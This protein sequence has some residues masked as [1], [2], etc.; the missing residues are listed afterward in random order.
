MAASFTYSEAS[1]VEVYFN[2][3][4]HT[5]VWFSLFT[6]ALRNERDTIKTI[7]PTLCLFPS[8]YLYVV[9]LIASDYSK[10][11]DSDTTIGKNTL[12]ILLKSWVRRYLSLD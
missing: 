5:E 4:Q 7:S 9:N 2:L 11:L 3:P 10:N 1:N 12:T 6:E 8:Y